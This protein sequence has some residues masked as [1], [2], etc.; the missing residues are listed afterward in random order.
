MNEGSPGNVHC[1]HTIAVTTVPDR[2]MSVLENSG[3]VTIY[4]AFATHLMNI[5]GEE[6]CT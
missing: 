5:Y 4:P 2:F 6:S 3:G 1:L